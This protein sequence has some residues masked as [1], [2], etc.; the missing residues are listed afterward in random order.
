MLWVIDTDVLV[1]AEDLA[2][3]HGMNIF[4]ML[5][6]LTDG[7]HRIVVDYTHQVLGQY[8]GNLSPTGWVFKILK[9]LVT[10]GQINYVSGNVPRNLSEGLDSLRF[11]IDDYV[12]VGVTSRSADRVL[13]AEES[14]Y[15]PDVVRFLSD[16]GISVINCSAARIKIS[17]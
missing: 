16:H 9:Q 8:Y 2:I 13:V 12:F 10:R 15:S 5:G 4:Q 7:N 3:D 17:G 6:R 1:R 14:D 11:D